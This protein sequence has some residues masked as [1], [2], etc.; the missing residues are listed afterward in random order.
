MGMTIKGFDALDKKLDAL[1][2]VGHKVGA[3]AVREGMKPIVE[4][5]KKD[6]PKDTGDGAK[7]LKT[8]SVRTYAKTGTAVA[9][10][11]INKSN[12]EKTKHLLFQHHGYEHKVSGKKVTI[13]VGWMTKSFNKSKSQGEK[14]MTN[15]AQAEIN[16]I[17]KS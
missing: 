12:F 17:L 14:I 8:T 10:A 9:R 4:Q 1:G 15:V 2:N 16:R 5:M 13:H 7:A 3:K 11:G 6:A